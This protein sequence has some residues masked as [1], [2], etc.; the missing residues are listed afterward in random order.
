M[1]VSVQLA[2]LNG[3][4]PSG[5]IVVRSHWAEDFLQSLPH[6][7][8]S[9]YI[10]PL[11]HFALLSLKNVIVFGSAVPNM[12]NPTGPI[13]R[14]RQTAM[15]VVSDFMTFLGGNL[16]LSSRTSCMLTRS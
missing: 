7:I 8:S 11:R 9:S 2:A 16:A 4:V 12:D 3:F 5:T 6:N 15:V 1:Y 10:D 14:G 13:D